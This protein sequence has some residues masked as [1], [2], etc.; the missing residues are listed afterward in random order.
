MLC[1]LNYILFKTQA[2]SLLRRQEIPAIVRRTLATPGGDRRHLAKIESSDAYQ[3][4][5][6]QIQAHLACLSRYRLLS[7]RTIF[8][9]VCQVIT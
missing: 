5:I 4:A 7:G 1:T 6:R 8:R 2:G 9:L 3:K